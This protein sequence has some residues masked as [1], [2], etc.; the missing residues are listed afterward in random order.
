M[1]SSVTAFSARMLKH[2]CLKKLNLLF[3]F[4]QMMKITTNALKSV[5]DDKPA[6]NCQ[7]CN[8]NMGVIGHKY[9]GSLFGDI[10]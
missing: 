8:F 10:L 1:L 6:Y 3:F 4:S 2:F 5:D 9:L 7:K